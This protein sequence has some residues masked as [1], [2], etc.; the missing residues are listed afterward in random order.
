[1]RGLDEVWCVAC[2]LSLQGLCRFYLCRPRQSNRPLIISHFLALHHPAD[3]VSIRERRVQHSQIVVLGEATFK[4]YV[5]NVC[6]LQ[7]FLIPTF[8]FTAEEAL[9]YDGIEKDVIRSSALLT[10]IPPSLS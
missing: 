8:F 7:F 3:A 6:A 4:Q 10:V 2:A 9:N 1:M 5:L